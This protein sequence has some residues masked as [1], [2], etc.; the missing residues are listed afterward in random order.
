MITPL[1]IQTKTF[2]NSEMGYKKAEVD[3]FIEELLRDYETLY[4]STN[5]SNFGNR[6]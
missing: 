3:A 2:S 6:I 1:D 5:D 4:K